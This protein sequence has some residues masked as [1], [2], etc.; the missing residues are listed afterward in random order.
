MG[1]PG[2]PGARAVGGA[3]GAE[4]RRRRAPDPAGAP[5][6]ARHG[7]GARSPG[8]YRHARGLRQDREALSAPQATPTR[9]K[10]TGWARVARFTS[11][12]AGEVPA[13]PRSGAR[14]GGAVRRTPGW[15]SIWTVLVIALG[16]R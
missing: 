5:R 12:P 6:A 4:R 9:L 8:R 1:A 11:P 7:S 3:H 16:V 14:G 15:R 10:E 13:V 2:G